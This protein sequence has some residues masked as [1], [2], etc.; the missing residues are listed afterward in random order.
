[1]KKPTPAKDVGFK[2]VGVVGLYKLSRIDAYKLP[3]TP[4]FKLD[5]AIYL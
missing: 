2:K 1:M 3:I 5:S 4:Y